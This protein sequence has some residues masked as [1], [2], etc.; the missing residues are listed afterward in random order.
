MSVIKYVLL[1]WTCAEP[2]VRAELMEQVPHVA[3]YCHEE[4]DEHQWMHL[5]PS[6]LL[7]L[8]VRYLTDVNNQV[9]LSTGYYWS[10]S[11]SSR[12]W[13][14]FSLKVRKTAQAAL[15]VLLEQELVARHDVEDQVCP[16]LMML[17]NADAH[18][19]FRT[20]A[21]AV[22]FISFPMFLLC[23][24]F[25]V[26]CFPC[27]CALA[28]SLRFLDLKDMGSEMLAFAFV[29]HL[30]LLCRSCCDLLSSSA[31]RLLL[32]LLPSS[33]Q[34]ANSCLLQRTQS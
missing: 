8:V 12:T 14:L 16:L 33:P 2:S 26:S 32:L 18:D 15:L 17:T 23:N 27:K 5:V 11:L 6:F 19:D 4:K 30:S 22:S 13:L 21:A 3:M 1:V 7:P 28:H 25:L 34:T 9:R 31:R 10:R 24:L 20:E 29:P